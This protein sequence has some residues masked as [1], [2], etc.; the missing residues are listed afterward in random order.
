MP[1]TGTN[2]LCKSYDEEKTQGGVY[3]PESANES[4]MYEVKLAGTDA[5]IEEGT[6]IYI[7]DSS[8]KP[9]T[10]TIKGEDYYIIGQSQVVYYE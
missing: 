3:V 9:N 6:V 1:T 2:L 4:N 8:R 7:P 5:D 10:I